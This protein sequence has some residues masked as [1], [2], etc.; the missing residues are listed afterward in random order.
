MA[1]NTVDLWYWCL[2]IH[3]FLFC[4]TGVSRGR[5]IWSLFF[6]EE[7]LFH[8][9][10]HHWQKKCITWGKQALV[11]YSSFL[12]VPSYFLFLVTFFSDLY[13]CI[14][15]TVHWHPLTRFDEHEQTSPRQVRKATVIAKLIVKIWYQQDMTM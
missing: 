15:K 10:F 13:T 4:V 11:I 14:L 1:H 12:S 3:L 9:F 2:P 7:R 5:S 8:C 6:S